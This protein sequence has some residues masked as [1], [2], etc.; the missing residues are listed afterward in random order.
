MRVSFS[1]QIEWPWPIVI[2]CR[3]YTS[4]WLQLVID[5]IFSYLRS[6]YLFKVFSKNLQSFDGI[7]KYMQNAASY[8][9]FTQTCCDDG[10]INWTYGGPK[11]KPNKTI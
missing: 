9:E 3:N 6:V 11:P 8:D 1:I 7:K 10:E 4:P 2:C 5:A